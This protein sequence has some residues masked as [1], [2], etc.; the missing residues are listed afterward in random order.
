MRSSKSAKR[1]L[2]ALRLLLA[3]SIAAAGAVSIRAQPALQNGEP[4]AAYIPVEVRILQPIS[5]VFGCPLH[6]GAY[7]AYVAFDCATSAGHSAG[8][9]I[10]RYASPEA[11]FM[12]F[13]SSYSP[14]EDFHGYLASSSQITQSA[15]LIEYHE[16]QAEYWIFGASVA[17][18]T[19][20][21]AHAKAISED[22]YQNTLVEDLLST[23][24]SMR[25][26]PLVLRPSSA[27]LTPSVAVP[28]G[29]IRSP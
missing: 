21:G 20:Y 9:W 17:N 28:S 8:A 2:L 25:F 14:T 3:V 29:L 16:W 24:P 10:R 5:Q 13:T 19:P 15:L 27:S 1:C 11:A 7:S 22:V 6:I 23:H 4:T 18:D 12:A 26:V